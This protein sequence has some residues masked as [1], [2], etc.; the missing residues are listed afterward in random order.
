MTTWK[1][2][3]VTALAGSMVAFSAQAVD[4]SISGSMKMAYTADSGKNDSQADGNRF[5]LSNSVLDFEVFMKSKALPFPFCSPS[6][7]QA[8]KNQCRVAAV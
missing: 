8:K 1:K 6:N 2:A 7:F 4:V 5:C 3:G